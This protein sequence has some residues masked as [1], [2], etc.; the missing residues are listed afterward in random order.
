[1]KNIKEV[2]YGDE[3]ILSNFRNGNYTISEEEKRAIL[4]FAKKVNS[5]VKEG[6]LPPQDFAMYSE[7]MYFFIHYANEVDEL[8]E[9]LDEIYGEVQDGLDFEDEGEKE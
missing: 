1:M 6:K 9:L 2:V 7:I 4:E 3:G 8:E 5:D